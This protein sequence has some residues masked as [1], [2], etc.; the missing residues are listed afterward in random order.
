MCRTRQTRRH[1]PTCFARTR[2]TRESQVLQVLREFGESGK[3]SECRQDCFIHIKY[4]ICAINDLPYHAPT[5]AEA[6]QVLARLADIRQP[7]LLRLARLAN[8]RQPVLLRLTR[9]ANIRQRPFLKK[10]DSP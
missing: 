4:V 7:V 3:F 5:F 9:L 8:I 1:L 2:Q 10:C 6:W